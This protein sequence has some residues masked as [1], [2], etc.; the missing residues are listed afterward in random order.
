MRLIAPDGAAAGATEASA[1]TSRPD[2]FLAPVPAA[3]RP[4]RPRVLA[5]TGRW[6][7]A[8]RWLPRDARRVLDIGCASAYGTAALAGDAGRRVIGIERDRA[9]VLEATRRRPWLTVLE[10]DASELP[11]ADG[12]ADAVTML[13]VLEHLEHPEAAIAE[14]H[15]VLAPGGC[16]V[17][18]V[19][20]RGVLHGLDA[21][22]LYDGLCRDRPGLPPLAAPTTSGGHAHQHYTVAECEQLLRPWFTVERVARR[23]LGVHELITLGL[24]AVRRHGGRPRTVRALLALYVLVYLLEDALPTGPVAYHL[25]LRARAVTPA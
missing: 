12:V 23:G 16:L 2:P 1:A 3:R 14:A 25:M 8:R 20:H 7:R 17:L 6:G 4:R 9:A 10:G 5:H 18:S 21:L 24:L 22:N 13:D 15:R 19:P 11:A